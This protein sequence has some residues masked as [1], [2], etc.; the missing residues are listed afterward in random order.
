MASRLLRLFPC[1][2]AG[3]GL[4]PVTKIVLAMALVGMVRAQ[5]GRK[6]QIPQVVSAF[7][8]CNGAPTVV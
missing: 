7:R 3:T 5:V 4:P 2:G 8:H 6:I 1:N